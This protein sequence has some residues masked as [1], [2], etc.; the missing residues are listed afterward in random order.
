MRKEGV[1]T[2]IMSLTSKAYAK[3]MGAV[4]IY[5]RSERQLRTAKLLGQDKLDKLWQTHCMIFGLGGVGSYAAEAL[6]RVGIGKLTLVDADQ[7]AVSNLNRQLPALCSTVGRTKAEVALER[8]VDIAPDA[9]IVAVKAFH[10][11]QSPV[12]IPDD[13]NIVV[14]AV[15]TVT[16]K[17][18]L[19]MTCFQR[20]IP[21]I[22]CMGMGNRLDPTQIRIGDLFQTEGCPLCRVMRRELRKRGV[23][24]LRCVY[25]TE[26]ARS[27]LEGIQAEPKASGHPSP[28]SLPYVPSVAG[29]YMAYEVVRMLC[30]DH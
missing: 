13:V 8:L 28:G 1:L 19:A 30:G 2:I 9:E 11:P 27:G 18:D 23:S 22:S 15:D 10:L 25:S 12:A 26:L 14:D 3:G 4:M 20:Q 21:I 17:I 6:C 24:S 16:A 29:L 5:P 7:V